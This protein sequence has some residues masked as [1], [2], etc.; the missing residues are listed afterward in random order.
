MSYSASG[1]GRDVGDGRAAGVDWAVDVAGQFHSLDDRSFDKPDV[2]LPHAH[3]VVSGRALF[4]TF[5][6]EASFP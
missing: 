6:V 2:A 1:A 3:Y 5:G 4:G